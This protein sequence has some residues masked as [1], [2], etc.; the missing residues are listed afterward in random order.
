MV[1]NKPLSYKRHLT[2]IIYA[3]KTKEQLLIKINLFT[4]LIKTSPL[5]VFRQKKNHSL[6]SLVL[7]L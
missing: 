6:N 3:V 2:Y 4:A 5:R 1:T 7:R